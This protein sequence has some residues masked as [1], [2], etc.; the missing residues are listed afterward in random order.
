MRALASWHACIIV[1]YNIYINGVEGSK[2]HI[3][4]ACRQ[5]ACM[6][7]ARAQQGIIIMMMYVIM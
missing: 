3:P 2:T 6:G 7:G 1:S 4:T 5:H